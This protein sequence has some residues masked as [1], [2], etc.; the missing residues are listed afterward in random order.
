MVDSKQ[1]FS[2]RVE[3]YS[4]YRPSYPREIVDLLA[5]ECKLTAASVIA[6]VGSGTGIM[7]RLFLDNGNPVFAVEPNAEMR[8]AAE[9]SLASYPNFVSVP[10][11]AEET[12]L[13]AH[14]VDFV[15]AAQAFHWFDRQQA[16]EEFVRILKPD[17]WVVLTWNERKI[18]STPFLDDYEQMLRDY[19]TDYAA[20][21]HRRIDEAVLRE[22]FAPDEFKV[23]HLQYSQTFDFEGVKGRLLSSSYTPEPGHPNHNLML[24]R[25]RAIFDARQVNGHVSMEY[26]TQIYYGHLHNE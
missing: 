1:R 23:K 22:F 21:D 26:D 10:G 16:R 4:K 2:S 11:S 18:G 17:G 5:R 25:L 8:Q 15:L 6:D 7:S 13:A 24:D 3:N 19:A 12:T 9:L 14:S 20:V